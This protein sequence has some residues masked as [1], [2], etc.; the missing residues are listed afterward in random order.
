MSIEC[1]SPP[2]CRGSRRS[3]C[4]TM[5]GRHGQWRSTH[6][7]NRPFAQTARGAP[8]LRPGLPTAAIS[9]C[10]RSRS[11]C[12]QPCERVSVL[13]ET[14]NDSRQR[15]RRLHAV[16]KRVVSVA[17]V[18]QHD[19]PGLRAAQHAIG[20]DIFSRKRRVPYAERPANGALALSASDWRHP[21]IP[22]SVWRPEEPWAL[23]AC[24]LYGRAAERN[25]FTNVARRA[26]DELPVMIA[27]VAEDVAL[28]CSPF[29]DRRPALGV[30]A[31]HEER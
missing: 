26:P 22:L 2:T 14:A 16:A 24:A 5:W 12:G 19:R 30:A 13:A 31:E 1:P 25:V 8:G 20:N 7:P 3:R 29:D 27:V 23:A 15:S 17:V 10:C 18:E 28:G 6:A 4:L 11:L 21:R 9:A